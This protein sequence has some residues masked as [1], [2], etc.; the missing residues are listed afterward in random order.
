[1]RGWSGPRHAGGYTFQGDIIRA[2]R[3]GTQP[4]EAPAV[5]FGDRAARS[6]TA[7]KR[8]PQ[9]A[10]RGM[11]VATVGLTCT[12]QRHRRERSRADACATALPD[13][14]MFFHHFKIC[15]NTCEFLSVIFAIFANF[16]NYEINC[17][18]LGLV[19]KV[20][21]RLRRRE[22]IGISKHGLSRFPS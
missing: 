12:P 21:R 3:A 5:V 11:G 4:P 17:I 8:A 19:F 13:I 14:L 16:H 18:H 7:M 9:Q 10:A 1:M 6:P 20:S 22:K 15:E 2:R